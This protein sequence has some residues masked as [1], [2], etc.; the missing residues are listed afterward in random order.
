MKTEGKDKAPL[1]RLLQEF[2]RGMDFT[3]QDLIH[4]L[5]SPNSYIDGRL[6]IDLWENDPK[7]VVSLAHAYVNPGEVF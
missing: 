1:T 3:V 7:R 4:F 2:D 6:P 5:M